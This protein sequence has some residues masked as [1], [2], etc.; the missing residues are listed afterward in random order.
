MD[1]KKCPE[2]SRHSVSFNYHRGVWN[3]VYLDCNYTAKPEPP[4]ARRTV[5][6]PWETEGCGDNC[7]YCPIPDDEKTPS[8]CKVYKY[9]G[10]VKIKEKE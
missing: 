4:K 9:G 6:W 8:N 3:C 5:P 10:E 7:E 1:I 2:C